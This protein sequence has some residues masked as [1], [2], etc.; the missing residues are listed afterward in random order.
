MLQGFIDTKCS[1]IDSYISL[2]KNKVNNVKYGLLL[3][4]IIIT[5]LPT[6]CH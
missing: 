4:Y 5:P 6:H 2:G 1:N 3:N